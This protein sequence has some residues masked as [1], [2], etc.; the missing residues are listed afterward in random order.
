MYRSI[1][2]LFLA[3]FLYPQDARG[4][5]ITWHLQNTL[6]D[7]G[8][9]ITGYFDYDPDI[10]RYLDF[11][12]TVSEGSGFPNFNYNRTNSNVGIASSMFSDFVRLDV[13]SY[14]HLE[15]DEALTNDGGFRNLTTS[16]ECNNCGNFRYIVQG[17]VNTTTQVPEPTTYLLFSFALI[18]LAYR[19]TLK[20]LTIAFK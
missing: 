6:F 10:D 9:T 20:G 14:V 19:P 15:F 12:L 5:V 2:T 13:E 16:F 17:S 8:G 18:L 7:D 1:L 11:N 3:V 4:G